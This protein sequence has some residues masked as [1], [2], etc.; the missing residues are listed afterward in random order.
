MIRA[1]NSFA[2]NV[3]LNCKP[4]AKVDAGSAKSS[5]MFGGKH[6]DSKIY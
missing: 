5:Y 3:P 2:A 6:D 1:T 4:L